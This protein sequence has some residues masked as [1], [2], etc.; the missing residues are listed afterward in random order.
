[1]FVGVE[2]ER[3]GCR[4]KDSK[5]ML[6][7]YVYTV[8]ECVPHECYIVMLILEEERRSGEVSWLNY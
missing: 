3:E 7:I 6:T 8:H 4:K 2:R 5:D 1:M